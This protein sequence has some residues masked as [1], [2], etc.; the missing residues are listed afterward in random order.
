[1]VKVV[2]I[3]PA[4]NEEQTI[5]DVVKITQR[6]VDEVFVVDDGSNDGTRKKLEK[7]CATVLAHQ[8]N[9]GKWAALKV[10]FQRVLEDPEVAV[11]VQLD[12]DGQHS[13]EEIPRFTREIRRGGDLV[14]GCRAGQRDMPLIRRLSNHVSTKLINFIFGFRSVDSQSGF[15]AYNQRTLKKINPLSKRYEGETETLIKAKLMG[16]NVVEVPISANFDKKSRGLF[17]FRYIVDCLDFA[18][19]IVTLVVFSIYLQVKHFE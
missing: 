18:K 9:Q 5:Y 7:T 10:G 8:K 15:R 12:G 3:L 14:V 4:H 19:I 17:R 13:P 16:L 11:I 6:Y 1:M 2:A